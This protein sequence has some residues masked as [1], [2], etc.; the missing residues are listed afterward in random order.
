MSLAI[1]WPSTTTEAEETA[2]T[3]SLGGRKL[4]AFTTRQEAPAPKTP[5]KRF[6]K[7]APGVEQVIN[8]DAPVV[9]SVTRHDLAEL[10][11]ADPT[12]GERPTGPTVSP[13]KNVSIP[14]KFWTLEFTFK[15]M[16]FI[17]IDVPNA[18]GELETQ[19]VWYLAYHVKNATPDAV[20]FYPTF[21][22]QN[23]ENS[24]QYADRIMPVAVQAIQ[25]REDPNRKLLD[26]ISIEG[27]IPAGQTSWGVATWVGIDPSMD[28]FAV[29]IR[30]LSNSYLWEGPAE[31]AASG[32]KLVRKVLQL[33]FWRPGDALYEHESEIRY[34]IP[35][36]V[37][38]RWL[39]R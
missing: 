13:A 24:R 12:Y 4:A 10:L 8:A 2:G 32:R 15:P 19:L 35:G 22:L 25:Q 6:R 5:P 16:R 17:E 31:D 1:L 23:L 38:Y 14:H 21:T 34:G 33:N 29:F 39:Y 27:E 30:G 37:D 7:L 20:N 26:T 18:A 3:T 36:D 9:E 28:R 11:K